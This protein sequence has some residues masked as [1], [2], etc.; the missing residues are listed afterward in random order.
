MTEFLGKEPTIEDYWR[1]IILYGNNVACYK[2]ALGKALLEIAPTGKTFI[3]LEELAEPF[4]RYIT[5]HLKLAEKQTTS[6]SSSFLE[7]CDRFNQSEISKD[8]LIATTV[9]QGFENVID[10]FHNVNK[11][12]LPVRFFTDERRSQNK[13]IALTD[14]LLELPELYQ[15]QNLPQEVEARWRLVETAWKLKI[16]K[17][18]IKVDYDHEKKIIFT[19][20]NNRRVDVT[21]C[22]DAL[23]GYQKGKCFYCFADISIESGSVDLGDVDHFFPRKLIYHNIAHPIDGVWNLVLACQSCNRG[24]RGKFDRL[25]EKRFLKRLQIRNDFFISS[26][27]PLRETLIQQT[28]T[29]PTKRAKFLE[30]NYQEA[31]TGALINSSWQPEYE[32]PPA[33]GEDE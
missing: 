21:S 10:A 33:F 1:S 6:R 9:R 32:H 25:P 24:T 29:T 12:E 15:G 28:G 2:F 7:A 11:S 8:E 19:G 20:S 26:H 18:L 13:G 4:S 23:N 31:S 17:H 5:E 3:T 30:D 27:H 16:S 14:S 22:R